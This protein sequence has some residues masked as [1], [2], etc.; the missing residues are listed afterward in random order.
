MAGKMKI[1]F[2]EF[3]QRYPHEKPAVRALA[4][5]MREI[6]IKN[7]NAVR[8]ESLPDLM[9][10]AEEKIKDPAAAAAATPELWCEYC[11]LCDHPF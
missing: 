6:A 10:F 5:D 11:S 3:M 1:S 7:P 9:V 2:Y 8:I 4:Y